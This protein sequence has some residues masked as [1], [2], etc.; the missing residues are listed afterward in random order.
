MR[1]SSRSIVFIAEDLYGLKLTEDRAL[2]LSETLSPLLRCAE[3]HE[4]KVSFDEE[5]LSSKQRM[6]QWVQ[7]GDMA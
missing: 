2:E 4:L 7:H 3:W 5:I 6:M 1:I